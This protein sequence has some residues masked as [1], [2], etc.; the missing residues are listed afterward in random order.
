MI[1]AVR[2][3]TVICR[4]N[5]PTLST[6]VRRL[7]SE[8]KSNTTIGFIGLGNMGSP[9]ARNI[10]AKGHK[11]VVYDVHQ[12][13]LTALEEYGTKTASSPQEV[14]DQVECLITMLP[15][16][17]AVQEAY[18]GDRGIL[19][20][21]KKGAMLIDSSTIDPDLSKNVA[22]SAEE[23]GAMFLDA[24]VS[25][26]VNA[27]RQGKLT[28]MV[29]GPTELFPAAQ[30]ILFTMGANVV[31]CGPVGSGQTAKLCNNML[32]AV[33]MIGT[34]EAMNLGIRLGLDPK[35]LMNI[36]NSSTGRCWASEVYC[37]VPGTLENVPSSNNY[38][39]GFGTKLML[40]DLTLAQDMATRTTTPT[41]L[42]SLAQEVY[43]NMINRGFADKDFSS[44]YQFIKEQIRA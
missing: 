32:L 11:L 7:S 14:A 21:V 24:P 27:A 12:E 10:I 1:T 22:K 2:C 31:H 39:G 16:N 44:V 5:I 37:P 34:A 4:L 29:G 19:K 9:M 13:P 15:N 40:K 3:C 41:P 8:K 36:F 28:F 20:S 42:G 23:R 35:L 38:K 17:A 43:S 18:C 26:G 25:G 6:S 30:E 33:S